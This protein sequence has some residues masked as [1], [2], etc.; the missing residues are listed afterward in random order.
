MK[1]IL[2]NWDICCEKYVMRR[3]IRN[4]GAIDRWT[5]NANCSNF[6]LL[7]DT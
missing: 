5:V 1:Q 3:T 2:E 6:F 7:L 4:A